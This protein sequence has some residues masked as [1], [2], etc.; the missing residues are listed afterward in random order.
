MHTTRKAG[1]KKLALR[2][3]SVV[4]DRGD[5]GLDHEDALGGLI[6]DKIGEAYGVG[7]YFVGVPCVL[8]AA[9]VEKIIEID[10]DDDERKL[11]DASVSHVK[12]LVEVVRSTFPDLA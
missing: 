1:Y 9:G 10:L 7:G 3:A 6:G 4:S 5:E 8:G 2:D 12:D 11:M